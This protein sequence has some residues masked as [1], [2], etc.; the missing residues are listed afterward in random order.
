MQK[1]I[2]TAVFNGRRLGMAAATSLVWSCCALL[3]PAQEATQAIEST[4]TLVAPVIPQQVRYAG[5]LANRAGIRW[6][7]CSASIPRPR[8]AKRFGLRRS[9]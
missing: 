9:A 1:H 5:V 8:A 4:A 2:G 7:P 3:S 6:K